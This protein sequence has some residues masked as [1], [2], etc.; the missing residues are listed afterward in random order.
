MYIFKNI[1]CQWD[2]RS[3]V[4][5]GIW[6]IKIV[7]SVCFTNWWAWEMALGAIFFFRGVIFGRKHGSY[8]NLFFRDGFVLYFFWVWSSSVLSELQKWT[9]Y[10]YIY[11]DH[12]FWKINRDNNQWVGYH[13]LSAK[14]SRL[15]VIIFVYSAGHLLR[16]E[17]PLLRTNIIT[18]RT[19]NPL[20][21]TNIITLR[22][23]NPLL[24]THFV[25]YILF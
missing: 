11:I 13:Q 17:N 20:L 22:T 1:I 9:M 15:A 23:E 5:G 18:L 16:T 21:R 12:V 14:C 4:V 25:I 7:L 6:F 19:E 24:R 8:R 3:S 2:K 10:L